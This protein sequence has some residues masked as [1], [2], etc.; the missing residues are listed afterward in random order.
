M[1]PKRF[2]PFVCFFAFLFIIG[3]KSSG[4]QA[5]ADVNPPAP[6]FNLEASDPAAIALA[7]S[8][9]EAMG[10]RKAWDETRYIKW[11]FF[12]NRRHVWDKHTNDVVI[13]G[14]REDFLIK[15][16]LDKMEGSANFHGISYTKNDSLD[17]YLERGKSMWINDSY[18]LLMPYKLKDSGVTLKYLGKD[19]TS[20]GVMSE[21]LELTFADVGVTPDNK[22]E[23]YVDPTSK[24]V[25]QWDFYTNYT[26]S[27]PR[28]KI[29]WNNY[30]K[31]GNILLSGDR[32]GN[33][34]LVEI[35]VGDSLAIYFK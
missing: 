21:K 15:M 32:G 22:Y 2:L 19:T 5:A 16:N 14:L 17:S 3:C 35:A 10:G 6:G 13:E 27:I 33:R 26:D 18:W 8:V 31:H 29:P 9:M 4:D 24:L 7:D 25:T 28:F 12:S 23:I 34:Q 1:Q 20:V 11:N 30:E